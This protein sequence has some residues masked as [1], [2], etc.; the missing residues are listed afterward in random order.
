MGILGK[1]KDI[2]FFD[3]EVGIDD[4]RVHDIGAVRKGLF[5][6]SANLNEFQT[7]IDGAKYVI[8]VISNCRGAKR[9][10]EHGRRIQ[11]KDRKA[12]K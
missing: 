1:K 5:F 6:H 2:V 8:I 10:S 4:K 11:T 3:T 12:K 9:R 7:F